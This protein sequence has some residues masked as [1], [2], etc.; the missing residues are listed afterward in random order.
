MNRGHL[1]IEKSPIQTNQ[2][3]TLLDLFNTVL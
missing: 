2:I 3:G 1:R